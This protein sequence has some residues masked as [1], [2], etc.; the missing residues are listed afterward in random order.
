MAA[1][2]RP[3]HRRQERALRCPSALPR[4]RSAASAD[5]I[6][7][8]KIYEFHP[9][10]SAPPVRSRPS[11][12]R[13]SRA[14]PCSIDFRKTLRYPGSRRRRRLLEHFDTRSRWRCEH[15]AC[16]L[17]DQSPACV[18]YTL[19]IA[20]TPAVKV[21]TGLLYS[22]RPT[23]SNGSG[24]PLSF[25]ISNKPA[26]RNSIPPAA[27]SRN[28]A[29]S[30]AGTYAQIAITASA[31]AKAPLWHRLQLLSRPKVP[32]SRRLRGCPQHR[33][34][35]VGWRGRRLS[36]VLRNEPGGNDPGGRYPRRY[37][38]QLR[39]RWPWVRPMVFRDG[40]G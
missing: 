1:A 18:G 32:A 28:P 14:G 19:D 30:D 10:I 24:A 36:S 39:C 29:A 40:I 6:V 2:I 20:G 35:I 5:S 37:F 17:L 23:T 13:I 12:S 4:W 33:R 38:D 7:V 31:A 26:W 25:A 22:F 3:Q 27:F 16:G 34:P 21:T 9:T 11:R 15:Y 8:G